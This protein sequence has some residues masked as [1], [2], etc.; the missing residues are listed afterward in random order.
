MVMLIIA[1]IGMPFVILYSSGV[2]YI[3]RGRSGSRARAIDS[4]AHG[5]DCRG[6]SG[7]RCCSRGLGSGALRYQLLEGGAHNKTYDGGRGDQRN[8]I[9]A[10]C[11]SHCNRYNRGSGVPKII[12]RA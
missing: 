5:S 6:S 7:R 4:G 8:L 9:G 3:F 1:L 12:A 11:R 10:G 2:Y